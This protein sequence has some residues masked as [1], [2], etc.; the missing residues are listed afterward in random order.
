MNEYKIFKISYNS[1]GWHCGD[2][3]HFYY[4]AKSEEEVKAN[5]QMYKEFLERQ[6]LHG[7][8]IWAYEFDGI[9]CLAAW[10]NLKDFEISLTVKEKQ[11]V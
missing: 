2:F 9:N 1:G 3:P 6:N 11:N 4:I 7:G 10:E 8:D 5:S